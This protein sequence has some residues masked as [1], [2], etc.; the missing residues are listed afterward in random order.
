IYLVCHLKAVSTDSTD[1]RNKACSY[2]H[3]AAAW[4][5]HE[6]KDCS[7]CA[8]PTGC[9]SK[10]RKRGQQQRKGLFGE[11]DLRFGPITL[12]AQRVNSSVMDT[13]STF[14]LMD[15]AELLPTDKTPH[16][17]MLPQN[18]FAN[19]ITREEVIE[20]ASSVDGPIEDTTWRLSVQPWEGLVLSPWRLLL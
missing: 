1:H 20:D 8:S 4:S 12:E 14:E 9:E 16:A 19:T 2:D 3:T 7:C 15:V 6:G 13:S 10:R 5:S 18:Q 11:A 17:T